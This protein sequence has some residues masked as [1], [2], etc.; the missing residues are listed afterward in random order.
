[1]IDL[2]IYP[3]GRGIYRVE[4]DGRVI[5]ERSEEPL[6]DGARKLHAEGH[7]PGARVSLSHAGS[8]HHSLVSTVGGAANL[9]VKET[10]G[11]IGPKFVQYQPYTGPRLRRV[12]PP[13]D[14]GGDPVPD[15]PETGKRT[16]G[17]TSTQR[18]GG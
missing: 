18:R 9:T 6:L 3:L 2:V 4:C 8:P 15:S 1:M 17:A 11:G 7:A 13:S 14:F 16:S 12:A 5:C 10:A